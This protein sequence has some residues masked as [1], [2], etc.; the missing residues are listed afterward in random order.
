MFVT[1]ELLEGLQPDSELL[2]IIST[3]TYIISNSQTVTQVQNIFEI[4]VSGNNLI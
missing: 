2:R 4:M 3:S 1:Q